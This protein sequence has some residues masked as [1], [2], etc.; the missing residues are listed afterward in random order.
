MGGYAMG[1]LPTVLIIFFILLV[2]W[3][4]MAYLL[5]L[6][7]TVRSIQVELRKIQNSVTGTQVDMRVM[8]YEI[9]HVRQQTERILRDN[10]E[11][12]VIADPVQIG[13]DPQARREAMA[14]LETLYR[15]GVPDPRYVASDGLLRRQVPWSTH[16]EW[17]EKK[18]KRVKAWLLE[19]G[20]VKTYPGSNNWQL[21]RDR[22]GRL[23][24]LRRV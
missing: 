8:S 24:D 9:A 5:P 1:V 2:A 12:T 14:W 18:S 21:D 6:L 13:T 16:G 11:H 10:G 22:F 19:R 4:I 3:R 23:S 15:G 7:S 17:N 20:I